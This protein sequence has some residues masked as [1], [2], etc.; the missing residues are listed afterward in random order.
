MVQFGLTWFG[1]GVILNAGWLL[2]K[3]RRNFRLFTDPPA[4]KLA[5]IIAVLEGI[6]TVAFYLAIRE[7]ENPAIVSFIGNLGPVLVTLM[8]ISILGEKYNFIQV[9]G[10]ILALGGVFAITFFPGT[11]LDMIVQPG[12]QYVLFASMLFAIATIL[13]RKKREMLDPELMSTIRSVL[14]FLVF[15]LIFL[16]RGAQLSIEKKV[17]ADIIAGSFLETL[18]TIV[19]A[20]QALRYIEAA[21][22]SVVISMKAVWVLFGALIFLKTFPSNLELTGGFL[23]LTGLVMIS[24]GK[25]YRSR[26]T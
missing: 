4:L 16:I 26:R 20:Y 10:I 13:A 2:F 17:W 12:S 25:Y 11:D 19:F 5:V 24:L 7:M 8:G 14:L 18:L 6:A 3:K 23:S 21:K 1:T 22:T 15:I 9:G